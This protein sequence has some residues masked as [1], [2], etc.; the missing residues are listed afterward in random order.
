MSPFRTVDNLQYLKFIHPIPFIFQ[1]DCRIIRKIQEIEEKILKQININLKVKIL[2]ICLVT[3]SLLGFSSFLAL[4]S[5]RSNWLHE[6]LS[7]HEKNARNLGNS[8]SAQFYERY[9]DVQAFA[10]NPSLSSTDT[11]KKVETLNMYSAMYGIYDLILIVDTS[12][13][14]LAVNNKGANGGKISSQFLYSKNF[15][16][17]PW[18]KAVMSNSF[19]EDKQK[20]FTGTFFEDLIID[21]DVSKTYGEIR[22]G[23]GFSAP[24][25]NENGETVA[26]ISTRTSSSWFEVALKDTISSLEKTGLSHSTLFLIT[27]EMSLLYSKEISS[28]ETG[29]SKFSFKKIELPKLEY[30]FVENLLRGNSGAALETGGA[31]SQEEIIG[32]APIENPKFISN[33]NWG[34]AVKDTT[35]EALSAVLNAQ[36]LFLTAFNLSLIISFF[37]AWKLSA[38][39]A[40]ALGRVSLELNSGSHEVGIAAIELASASSDL[41][42]ASAKQS[43]AL[44]QTSSAVEEI[45]SMVKRSADLAK[46]ADQSTTESRKKAE[47]GGE[48]VK[49]MNQSMVAINDNTEQ[50][51]E[52]MKESNNRIASIQKVIE[53][54][55]EKTNVINDIVFQTKLLSF[56]ASVEAARAGEHGKGFAVVAEEVGNL[57]HMSGNAAREINHL[58]EESTAN[59]AKIV[60]ETQT[61]LELSLASAKIVVNNGNLVANE[62]EQVL[63]EIV[64]NSDQ[65]NEMVSSIAQASAESSQGVEEISKALHQMNQA[66]RTN[67][68]ASKSCAISSEKL[69]VQVSGLRD[70]ANALNLIVD[71]KPKLTRFELKESYLLGVQ[72]MDDEHKELVIRI[73][74]L[75]DA[76]GNR[77]NTSLA[78]QSLAEFTAQHF[79]HEEKYMASISYPDLENHK[80]IHAKLLSQVGIFGDQINNHTVNPAELINFLNDWLIK[81]ILGVDMKYAHFSRTPR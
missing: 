27:K 78:F 19:T 54:I 64:E 62:C 76:L 67:A 11:R 65:I 26:V 21:A 75:A 36:K 57:A 6:K 39:I 37:L 56:N 61:K 44:E 41:S 59:V 32:Y 12:G 58:L 20:R 52:Q 14:L 3:S 31:Q 5:I 10:I 74:A 42:S 23:S 13:K 63:R 45:S 46:D 51:A 68:S 24:I 66:V 34:T 55:G 18:F 70:S 30:R 9:G 73:N 7:N 38:Q 25:R 15:S 72:N 48:I 50:I 40:K 17:T 35:E 77:N 4:R 28:K 69:N 33:L 29:E 1:F 53:E 22:L 43:S 8:I 2:A 47:S 16:Q 71:G 60:N 81:H 49:R 80:K 79:N